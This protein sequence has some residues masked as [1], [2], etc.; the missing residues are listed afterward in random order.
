MIRTIFSKRTSAVELAAFLAIGFCGSV[1]AG[2]EQMPVS[3]KDKEVQ[4]EQAAAVCDPRWYFS[5][6]GGIDVDLGSRDLNQALEPNYFNNT[7]TTA[8]I[9][10]HDWDDVYDNAWRIQGEFGYALT[11]HLEVFALFKYAHA[12]ADD[13][14]RGSHADFLIVPPPTVF[15]ISSEFDDYNS[16]GGELGFRFFFLP[17]EARWRPYIALSGGATHTDSIGIATHVDFSADGGPSDFVA[18][19]GGFFDESWVGTGA[20][21]LGMEYAL[22]CHW[23]LGVNAGVRY[24]SSLDDDDSDFTSD[25]IRFPGSGGVTFDGDFLRPSNND[26]GDRFYCPVTGYV[27][28]RF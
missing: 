25:A 4:M 13:R 23:T 21:V 26:A 27:K 16:W 6:G 14:T 2:P 10:E 5:I 12:D 19:G 9:N 22:N 20:A 1:L 18:Y 28:F 17:R 24:E 8:Y 15:P 7:L 11:Q 3:S